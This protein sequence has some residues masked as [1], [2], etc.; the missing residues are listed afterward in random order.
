M[1]EGVPGL[2]RLQRLDE[3]R[4]RAGRHRPRGR[5][6]GRG[7]ERVGDVRVRR[8][9]RVGRHVFR[10]GDR[11]LLRPVRM[12]VPVV[13]VRVVRV[14]V[15]VV[16]GEVVVVV[17]EGVHAGQRRGRG[18][19]RRVAEVRR[20]RAR[21]GGGERDGGVRA[22]HGGARGAARRGGRAG[23]LGAFLRSTVKVALR[24]AQG[25]RG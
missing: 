1:D 9:E 6:R 20:A 18:P 13:L 3:V 17:R 10:G 8:V 19:R 21:V 16:V 2:L 14:E 23:R 22:V 15:R 4:A 24:S 11:G 25:H 5:R 7:D 12:P